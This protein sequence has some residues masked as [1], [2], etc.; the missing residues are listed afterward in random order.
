MWLIKQNR[1]GSSQTVLGYRSTIGTADSINT[2]L[3]PCGCRTKILPPLF[4]H[5]VLNKANNFKRKVEN[6]NL[7]LCKECKLTNPARKINKKTRF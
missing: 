1:E 4:M 3:T 2:P 7:T 6:L 5:L